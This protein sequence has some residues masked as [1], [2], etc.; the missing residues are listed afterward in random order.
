MN[1]QNAGAICATIGIALGAFGAHALKESLSSNGMLDAWETAVLYHLIHA[2][3]LFLLAAIDASHPI[4]RARLAMGL[5]LAGI[6][7][8]SGSLYG[9]ALTQWSLLG[10]ITPIGG[11]CF[12]AGWVVLAL[13]RK[14]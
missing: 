11:L 2:V 6:V 5:W 1:F 8:F 3:S 12:M 13:P 4:E 14:A 10:P 9:L 7:L